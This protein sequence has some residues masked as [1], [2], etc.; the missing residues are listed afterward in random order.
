M[1]EFSISDIIKIGDVSSY[2]AANYETEGSLFGERLATT[3][4]QTIKIVT[5]A[6]KWQW[7]AFPDFS[8][9][10]A[11]G[12][13]TINSC[14][15][16]F[17]FV[18]IF[19]ND[20]YLGLISFGKCY[21]NSSNDPSTIAAGI[22]ISSLP[23]ALSYGYNL[24]NDISNPTVIYIY[25]PIG[26]GAI[27]NGDNISLQ[28]YNQ[29]VLNATA[30]PFYGGINGYVNQEARGVANYL[31]WLCGKFGLEAQYVIGGNSGGS[32]LPIYT[33]PI[34]NAIDF[35]VAMSGSF[36]IN[37]QST[38]IIPSFVNYNIIFVRSGIVQPS[39]NLGGGTSYYYWD[40]ATATFTCSPAAVEGETFQ[41]IPTI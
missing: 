15:G 1:T 29:S 19:I 30:S 22:Q 28:I 24:S 5:D 34:P 38:V 16:D 31:Q 2:I 32:V 3:S 9:T 41:I 8:E 11:I 39:I 20:P 17:G 10:R 6:L 7:E 40:K 36:M 21:Y 23:T 25:A 14:T 18:E 27:I 37:G 35:V 26:Y 13:V 4:P 33:T 12:S